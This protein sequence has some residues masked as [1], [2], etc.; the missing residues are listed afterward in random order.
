MRKT[1]KELRR[2]VKNATKITNKKYWKNKK[3]TMKITRK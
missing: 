2:N 3:Y 1:K